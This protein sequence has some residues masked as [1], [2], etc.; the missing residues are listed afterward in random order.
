MDKAE[1]IQKFEKKRVLLVGDTILDIYSKGK[2]VCL[3]SD[4]E[5]P[6]IEEG[7]TAVSFG[8]A[9]L[10]ANNIL[11]LGGYVLFFS[12]VGDDEAAKYYEKFQHPN[13]EKHLFVDKARP[14][15]VKKRFWVDDKKLFQANQVDNR[16]IESALGEKIIKEMES[17]IKDVDVIVV[18]DAQHG[19]LSQEMISGL[20]RLSQ[21]YEKPMYVD[22]QISHRP[23]NHHLYQG[24]DC[25]FFN[26]TEARAVLPGFDAQNIKG[27]L[28]L[29]KEKL[30]LNNIVIKL[31]EQG[32]AALFNSQFV[33]GHPH[34]VNAIDPC[35]AGDSFLAAFS[36]GDRQSPQESLDIA[37]AWAA[38][39]T[40]ILG[41]VPPQKQDLIKI[42]A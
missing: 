23:S 26:Q 10:I 31:G 28:N 9:S 25:L 37:N 41:T 17:F 15:I 16:Y 8:G 32:S 13:L 29:L 36:V 38:L 11:E 27:S 20:K 34:K 1:I 5:A 19:L 18:L 12:V 35:G 42:Y 6:E 7:E 30:K 40:T 24:V 39:S 4:S 22:S 3:S 2:I 33:Q 21:K 14:T